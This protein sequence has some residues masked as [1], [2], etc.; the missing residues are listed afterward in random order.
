M[1]ANLYVE[2]KKAKITQ[3][4]LSALLGITNRAL[5]LKM[6]GGDF[7]SDE[8]FRIKET[9]FP[10]KTLEYLFDRER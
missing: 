3:V 9:F 1:F 5:N 10:E 6:R 4:Q 2:M 8:M 7:T